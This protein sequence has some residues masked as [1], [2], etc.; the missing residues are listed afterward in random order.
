LTYDDNYGIMKST[1]E[2]TSDGVIQSRNR[3]T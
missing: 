2:V 3:A 1:G